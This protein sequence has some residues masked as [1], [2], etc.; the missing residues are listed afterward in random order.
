M[1][2]KG[3]RFEILNQVCSFTV[4]VVLFV[5]KAKCIPTEIT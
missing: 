3:Q 2:D 5:Q 1:C 4:D